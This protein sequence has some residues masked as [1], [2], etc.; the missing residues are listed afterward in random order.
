MASLHGDSGLSTQRTLRYN[1][2]TTLST[3][4]ADNFVEADYLFRSNNSCLAS[5]PLSTQASKI[6]GSKP[7]K[8]RTR[9][10]EPDYIDEPE[11]ETETED[12]MVRTRS[13]MSQKLSSAPGMQLLQELNLTCETSTLPK[14]KSD[15]SQTQTTLFMSA[16]S[17]PCK[18][19][20][21][22]S[23]ISS[24]AQTSPP[25]TDVGMDA[26]NGS[27]PPT[28]AVHWHLH[29]HVAGHNP[30]NRVLHTNF[31]FNATSPCLDL[32]LLQ[33][34]LARMKIRK[35]WPADK[36]VLEEFHRINCEYDLEILGA[37]NLEV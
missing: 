30:H 19:D 23:S 32:Q 2:K 11:S 16:C 21:K 18:T 8:K 31:I 14:S 28:R 4:Y 36:V 15:D 7:T 37:G 22:S 29:T 20:L 26:T 3:R 33:G 9:Q 17:L 25:D 5:S 13:S 10:K 12:V 6:A 1:A 35:P 34:A 27:T 24:F